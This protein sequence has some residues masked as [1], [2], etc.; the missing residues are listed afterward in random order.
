MKIENEYI[1]SNKICPLCNKPV[2]LTEDY[3]F[4][5]TKVTKRRIFAHK[6]CLRKRKK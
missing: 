6:N 5:L 3:I 4:T 1:K 2:Y